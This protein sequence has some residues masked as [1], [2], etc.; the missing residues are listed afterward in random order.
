MNK[1]PIN[2]EH[3]PLVRDTNAILQIF[4]GATV[5]H[6]KQVLQ[7]VNNQIECYGKISVPARL[8]KR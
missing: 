4:K 5:H 8:I 1:K 3:I 7:Q 2:N 6:A